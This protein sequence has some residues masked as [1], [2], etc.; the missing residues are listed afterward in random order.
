VVKAA[1]YSLANLD[2]GSTVFI[3]PR[4][5]KHINKEPLI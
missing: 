5:P 1:K 3:C 2:C 4:S